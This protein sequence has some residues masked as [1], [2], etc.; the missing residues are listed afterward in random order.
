[1]CDH[2]GVLDCAGLH[3]RKITHTDSNQGLLL[4]GVSFQGKRD[5]RESVMSP[6]K[7]KEDSIFSPFRRFKK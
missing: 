1:M 3:N 6:G 5:K 4:Q 7:S 2:R